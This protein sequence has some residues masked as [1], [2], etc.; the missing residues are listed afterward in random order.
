[1]RHVSQEVN[2]VV[3]ITQCIHCKNSWKPE[4]M[5]YHGISRLLRRGGVALVSTV[6]LS[7]KGKWALWPRQ[8]SKQRWI[9]W[10]GVICDVSCRITRVIPCQGHVNDVTLTKL[11]TCFVRRRPCVR[12]AS[13]YFWECFDQGQT[14][15]RCNAGFW[16]LTFTNCSQDREWW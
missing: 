2:P 1:M 3:N 6:F 10:N 5:A 16:T 9:G 15:D 13:Y 7:A 14:Q 11:F 4:R 12:N 8:G